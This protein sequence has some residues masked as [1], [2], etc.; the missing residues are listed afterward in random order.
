[1]SN[2][3]KN[4]VR[5]FVPVLVAAVISYLTKLEKHVPAGELVVIVPVISTVYYAVV[6]NLEVRF[7]KL[8]WLLGALPV[9]AAGTTPTE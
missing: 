7:P 1:M 9:K 6:R 8:S 3:Q 5:T 2:Y 4:I